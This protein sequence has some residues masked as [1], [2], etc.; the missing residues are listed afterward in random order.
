MLLDKDVKDFAK[1]M[2]TPVEEIR[3]GSLIRS[4]VNFYMRFMQIAVNAEH[5]TF[6]NTASA[7]NR[8]DCGVLA[9]AV[10]H[11]ADHQGLDIE[12][13]SNR[14]HACLR[15]NNKY[16]D[17]ENLGGI[18]QYTTKWD[19]INYPMEVKTLQQMS[20]EFMPC[21][22][23]GALCIKLWCEKNKHPFPETIQHCLINGKMYDDKLYERIPSIALLIFNKQFISPYFG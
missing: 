20:D 9:I 14:H 19:V 4:F 13:C 23:L 10:G 5:K 18:K 3:L 1:L 11:A 12:Y 22:L 16:F 6:T 21:D 8:G 2:D 17:S 15:L 7:I